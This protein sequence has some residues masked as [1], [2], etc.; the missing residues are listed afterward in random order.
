MSTQMLKAIAGAL[1]IDTAVRIELVEGV[2]I[3]RAPPP[4]QERIELLLE[5]E[6]TV[7]LNPDEAQELTRYEELDDFL[8]L[9]NRLVRNEIVAANKALAVTS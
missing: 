8:S 4:V 2:P 3:F 6:R 1:P 9:V 5:R 7:A